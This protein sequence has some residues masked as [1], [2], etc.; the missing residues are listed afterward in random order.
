MS[1]LAQVKYTADNAL[2][3]PEGGER[4][5]VGYMPNGTVIHASPHERS[6]NPA[7]HRSL[8]VQS[9]QMIRLPWRASVIA[10]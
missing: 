4:Q 5:K 9:L 6:E 8:S 2:E 3:I 10:E 1:G 7:Q